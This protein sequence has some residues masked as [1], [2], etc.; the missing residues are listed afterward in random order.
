MTLVGLILAGMLTLTQTPTADVSPNDTPVPDR[1]ALELAWEPVVGCPSLEEVA[2][3]IT[4]LVGRPPVIRPI[5]V[6]GRAAAK[7]GRW[8]V[9]LSIR[10]AE[11]SESRVLEGE[12]CD[13]VADAA[14]VVVALTIDPSGGLTMPPPGQEA[15]TPRVVLEPE[16]SSPPATP[17]S[18]LTWTRKAW[19]GFLGTAGVEPRL[20][21]GLVA[22]AGVTWKELWLEATVGY[23]F[24]QRVK[25]VG[26]SG[27]Q[28][29]LATAGLR[30]CRA[31]GLA[32]V[33]LAGCAVAET[34]RQQAK[35]FGVADPRAVGGTWA[36]VGAGMSAEV[37]VG[38]A[39]FLRLD[40]NGLVPLVRHRFEIE[41]VDSSTNTTHRVLAHRSDR[42][43]AELGLGLGVRF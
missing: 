28:V 13:A 29:S 31:H 43:V 17:A 25:V 37:D 8:R 32:A 11:T 2:H 39:S 6:T 21:S 42:V 33:Q 34:G 18:E 30:M 20:A 14:A 12:S 41:I 10:T 1:A 9:E 4:R 26:K 5:A 23:G 36:A 27:A 22:G 19:L 24:P 3:R 35:G 40:G 7:D 38:A 15:V 16:T